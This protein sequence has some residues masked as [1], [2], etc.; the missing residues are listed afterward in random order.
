MGKENQG[1][2]ENMAKIYRCPRCKT[3][4]VLVI[5]PPGG[6]KD[7]KRSVA[8]D[9]NKSGKIIALTIYPSQN[10]C[11]EIS[12]LSYSCDAKCINKFCTYSGRLSHFEVFIEEVKKEK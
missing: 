6:M 5:V 4:G 11:D 12:D 8:M 10:E 9:V 2:V 3:E 1:R 7:I